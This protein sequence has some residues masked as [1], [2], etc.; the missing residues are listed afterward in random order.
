MQSRHGLGV[1][2]VGGGSWGTAL[3]NLCAEIGHEVHM[4]VRSA[5][6]AEQINALHTN[7]RYLGDFVVH[8]ALRAGCDDACLRHADIVLLTVPSQHVRDM[9]QRTKSLLASD[10]I[11]VNAAKGIEYAGLQTVSQIAAEEL[12]LQPYAVLSGPSFAAELLR[13]QPTAVVLGCADAK[14]GAFLRAQFSN[15]YFRCYSSTDVIGVELGGA[16]KN[17][18]ALAAGVSDGLGFG[19]NARAAL[20]TRG[21]AETSRLGLK[22]GGRSATF[23]GL[24]GMGDLVLTC[25]G[26]LSRNRQVGLRLGRGESLEQIHESMHNVAEGVRTTA[27]VFQLARKYRVEMPIT[28]TMYGILNE[29]KN[30]QSAVHALMT[31]ELKEE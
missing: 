31:R 20:I 14:R 1:V 21:L 25:T 27:S 26:D 23:M 2:V 24:S 15:S 13:R 8:S 10:S 7:S 18:I 11:L 30:P 6:Q 29:G 3:A 17:I 4:L 16:I 28:A 5:E 9:L 22:M 12:P 19:H